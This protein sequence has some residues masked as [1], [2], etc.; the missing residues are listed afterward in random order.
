MS[1]RFENS[2]KPLSEQIAERYGQYIRLG[3]LKNGE[4]MPT[5][6]QAAS[7]MG[8]NPLTVRRAYA[9]LEQDGYIVSLDRK[10]VFVTYDGQAE[11]REEDPRKQT[12]RELKESGLDMET[13]LSWIADIY[14]R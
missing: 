8:V 6:R 2:G 12:V 5:I 3:I 4:A 13:L 1:F 9:I 14:A 11:K 7:E 10:G